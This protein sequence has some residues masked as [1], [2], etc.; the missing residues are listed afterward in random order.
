LP[1]L[2]IPVCRRQE[3]ALRLSSNVFLSFSFTM[4][5]ST[6]I[7]AGALAFSVVWHILVAFTA[8]ITI[9][10]PFLVK[11]KVGYRWAD[12][13]NAD[14]RFF[15]QPTAVKW[16]AG[17]AHPDHNAETNATEGIWDPMPGYEFTDK[18]NGLETVWK[19]GLQHPDYMAWADDV[20]GQWIPVT[21]YRFV[22][23]GDT[24]V[25]SVWDPG[26]RYDDLKVISLFEKDHYKPFP[27][28]KFLEPG[29]SLK[30]V[31]MPG[32]VNSDNSRLIAGSQEGSWVV[33]SAPVRR[34]Y[35]RSNDE[36]AAWFVGRVLYHAL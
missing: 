6:K 19:V 13:R 5:N 21:G 8:N 2:V 18:A 14:A 23:E 3:L 9:S 28:Y 24:F 4:K 29:T 31:W 36:A 26:K 25:A 16:E 7:V 15:G 30:V 35:N 17:M 11:P 10:G 27:G 32:L 22:Y 20:E 1:S 34:R 33:N 12:T